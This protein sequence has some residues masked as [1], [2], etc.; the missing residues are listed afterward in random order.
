MG[1]GRP[2]PPA[3]TPVLSAWRLFR[4]RTLGGSDQF[5]LWFRTAPRVSTQAAEGTSPELRFS[6]T[7][8][9]MASWY[10]GLFPFLTPHCPLLAL[11][12]SAAFPQTLVRHSALCGQFLGMN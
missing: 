9:E 2:G 3:G 12:R 11:A 6:H 8:A 1:R 4:G 10:L 7:M 5:P